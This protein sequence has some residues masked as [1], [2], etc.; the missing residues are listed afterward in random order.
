MYD[1]DIKDRLDV[2]PPTEEGLERLLNFLND[3]LSE[4][5]IPFLKP[6]KSKSNKPGLKVIK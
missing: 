2:F 5:V 1:D 3:K 4:E 6:H